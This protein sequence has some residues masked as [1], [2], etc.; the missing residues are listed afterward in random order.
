ME[1]RIVELEK[2]VRDLTIAL[3]AVAIVG[4]GLWIA[5]TRRHGES[6]DL[7][8][9]TACEALLALAT[10]GQDPDRQAELYSVT[11]GMTPNG[12]RRLPQC[13]ERLP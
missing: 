1:N 5:N 4:T 7:S 11:R 13:K 8:M 10:I 9:R 12:V 2:K 6:Q 3:A